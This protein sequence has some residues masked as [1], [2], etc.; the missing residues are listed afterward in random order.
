MR[1]L[2]I[3]IA[4]RTNFMVEIPAGK[5][6]VF[7]GSPASFSLATALPI[8]RIYI[9]QLVGEQNHPMRRE[10]TFERK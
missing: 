1:F 9:K 5:T 2:N 7:W 3:L 6:I 8:M 4:I 10:A